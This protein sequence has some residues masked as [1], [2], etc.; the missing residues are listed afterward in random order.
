MH[1]LYD[2]G[3]RIQDA[4]K[5]AI[6]PFATEIL[7]AERQRRNYQSFVLRLPGKKSAPR[8]VVISPATLTAVA[9]LLDGRREGWVFQRQDGASTSSRVLA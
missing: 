6:A 2:A 3:A 4:E 7:A 9:L 5:L 1:F 8:D